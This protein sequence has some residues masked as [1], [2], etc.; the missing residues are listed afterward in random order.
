LVVLAE[1]SDEGR[2]AE[3][4]EGSFDGDSV[5][6]IG[7]SEVRV[8]PQAVSEPNDAGAREELP[9]ALALD[10]PALDERRDG[11]LE[12]AAR[13]AGLGRQD[14]RVEPEHTR[15][16]VLRAE[17]EGE[18]DVPGSGRE[19]L[20]HQGWDVQL[21][22]YAAR[23]WRANFFPAGIAHSVG[24][25]SAWAHAPRLAIQRATWQALKGSER[26]T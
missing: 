8:E 23:D 20:A 14:S 22:A 9:G 19:G 24:G 3:W 2:F 21:T 26:L 11:P 4:Q 7:E 6:T 5:L 17:P 18:E 13:V 16:G 15:R 10:P 1:P 12:H 25:G